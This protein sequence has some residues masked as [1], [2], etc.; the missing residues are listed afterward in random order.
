MTRLD[1]AV[2]GDEARRDGRLERR[3]DERGR[4]GDEPVEDDRDARRGGADDHAD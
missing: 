2:G 4:T 1:G 3:S